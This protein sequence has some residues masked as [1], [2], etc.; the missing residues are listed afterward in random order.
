[1]GS[2]DFESIA[3]LLR[4]ARLIAG[5]FE[6]LVDRAEEGDLLFC[7]PPYTVRHNHN[8]FRKYNEVLFSWS[9]QERL[10]AALL[11]AVRRGAQVVAT[12]ANHESVRELYDRSE[13][14]V[15]VASRYSR[16]SGDNKSRCYF[17]ELIM[18]SAE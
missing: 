5:D 14:T 13:F 1:M 4:H 18:R 12:N 8:G 6:G 9:D 3:K 7:D 15:E 16:I 11:R 10:A 17:D 2:D